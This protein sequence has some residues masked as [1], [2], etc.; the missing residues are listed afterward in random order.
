MSSFK[1]TGL[2]SVT[3]LMHNI[4][5][6]TSVQMCYLWVNKQQTANYKL[7]NANIH[8]YINLVHEQICQNQSSQAEVQQ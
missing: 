3:C 5:P 2:G 1:E 8:S 7:I 4:V 6:N